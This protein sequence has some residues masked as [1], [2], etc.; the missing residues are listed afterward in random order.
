MPK[1]YLPRDEIDSAGEKYR[2]NDRVRAAAGLKFVPMHV[3]DL[4]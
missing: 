2:M 3:Q 4:S 1:R